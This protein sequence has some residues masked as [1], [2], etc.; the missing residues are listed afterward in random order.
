MDISKHIS[1]L[2]MMHDCVIVPN[3]GAFLANYVPSGYDAQTKLFCPSSKEVVFNEKIVRND[4]VLIAHLSAAEGI[5]YQEAF[6]VVDRFRSQ[7]FDAIY[8]GKIVEISG[9]GIL[10]LSQY[11]KI[12]FIS[13][14]KIKSIDAFG[15]TEFSF[16]KL[17]DR[18]V[19]R[20]E[21]LYAGKSSVV[22]LGRNRTYWQIAA[23]IALVLTLSLFPLRNREMQTSSLISVDVTEITATPSVPTTEAVSSEVILEETPISQDLQEQ[24][25]EK[26]P[27]IL[28]AGTFTVKKNAEMLSQQLKEQGH[29]SEIILLED[30]RFRV[31]IDSYARRAEAIA[32]MES[33]R[34]A[35]PTS[36][37]WVTIR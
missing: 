24:E 14:N 6:D 27:V 7:S 31:S 25:E 21:P 9:V 15:L 26:L 36:Q 13:F 12:D 18:H 1:T 19:V 4:G 37:A 22:A 20:T 23:S 32:A 34:Q 3:F 8:S 11:G 17:V 30:G 10:K 2:L 5:T 29:S 16:P 35:N 28:V 33:Y